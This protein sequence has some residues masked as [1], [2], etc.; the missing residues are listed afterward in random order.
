M[1]IL[2]RLLLTGLLLLAIVVPATSAYAE[3]NVLDP[4][5]AGFSASDPEAP[6][7][8]KD[9]QTKQ[10]TTDNS[11]YGKNG[12]IGKVVQLLAI[13]I[14]IVA[15]IMIIIGGLKYVMSSG[16]PESINSAKNTIL[17]AIIGLIV[18][19]LAQFIIVYVISKL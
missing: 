3:T 9:N 14:G 2:S 17:Y 1:K 12:I 5:C 8:C 6:T 16:N 11:I 15:V 7:I 13:L 10:S 18:A 19:V 4:A